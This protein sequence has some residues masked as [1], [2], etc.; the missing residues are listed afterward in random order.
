MSRHHC[1]VREYAGG[2]LVGVFQ[3]KAECANF[4]RGFLACGVHAFDDSVAVSE[5]DLLRMD[6]CTGSMEQAQDYRHAEQPGGR[7][8][9]LSS[10]CVVLPDTVVHIL[11][12]EESAG[13]GS[14]CLASCARVAFKLQF[15]A[16]H[17]RTDRSQE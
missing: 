7:V 17:T 2:R 3:T 13:P 10:V 1:M 9:F 8:C 5:R 14:D 15:E 16:R 4:G 6:D 12:W 11:E